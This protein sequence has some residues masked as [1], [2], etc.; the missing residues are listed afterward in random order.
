MVLGSDDF[1]LVG[2]FN[3]Q[4]TSQHYFIGTDTSNAYYRFCLGASASVKVR[5]FGITLAGV[6]LG[7]EVRLDTGTSTTGSVPIIASVH[8]SVDFG[9]FSIGGTVHIT[10]G[11]LQIPP[12]VWMGSDCDYTCTGL[13]RSWSRTDRRHALPERRRPRRLAQHRGRGRRRDDD[14]RADRRH[15]HR[16]HDQ[17]RRRTA[18]TTST[19]T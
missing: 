13:T 6:S 15:R 7:F 10:I 11:Y 2:N 3:F 17:G 14:H 9:L 1:G 19:S 12:P 5:A 8:V 18:A 4:V 16:R